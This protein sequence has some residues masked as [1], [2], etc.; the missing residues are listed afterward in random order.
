VTVQYHGESSLMHRIST[1]AVRK[2]CV[3]CH[4]RERERGG[5]SFTVTKR[6]ARNLS[7]TRKGDNQNETE[8]KTELN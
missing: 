2:P 4:S 1:A 6:I 8:N 3:V 7:S 5:T